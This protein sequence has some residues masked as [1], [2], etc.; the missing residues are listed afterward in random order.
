LASAYNTTP[1]VFAEGWATLPA[2]L[3]AFREAGVQQ[4]IVWPVVDHARQPELFCEQVVPR[5]G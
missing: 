4:V 5:L 3:D 2:K 1:A